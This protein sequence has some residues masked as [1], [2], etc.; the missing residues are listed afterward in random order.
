MI[1]MKIERANDLAK[2]KEID[3]NYWTNKRKERVKER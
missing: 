1:K 3:R 2:K